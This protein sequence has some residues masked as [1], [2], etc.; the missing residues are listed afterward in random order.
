MVHEY[1]LLWHKLNGNPDTRW[2]VQS[3]DPPPAG[4]QAARTQLHILFFFFQLYLNYN[5]LEEK[6]R[7]AAFCCLYLQ[8]FMSLLLVKDFFPLFVTDS[9]PLL[10]LCSGCA[11]ELLQ[12]WAARIPF[13]ASVSGMCTRHT[14]RYLL[15]RCLWKS[16]RMET[17]V[18]AAFHIVR[19]RLKLYMFQFPWYLHAVC[20]WRA[21]CSL[22]TAQSL[23]IS[24]ITVT[25]SI[26]W[27]C[28]SH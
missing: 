26:H 1:Q 3:S 7:V 15:L 23:S 2:S 25:S 19:R 22:I 24:P 21:N 27:Q 28:G 13:E 6:V 9:A 11:L 18:A 16:H 17:I 8:H 20:T 5:T 14:Q 10:S 12:R 4:L